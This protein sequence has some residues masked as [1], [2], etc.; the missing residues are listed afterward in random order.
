M[1]EWMAVVAHRQNNLLVKALP[2]TNVR[3]GLLYSAKDYH[4]GLQ[5]VLSIQSFN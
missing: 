4:T 1:N 5:S 2:L 3:C